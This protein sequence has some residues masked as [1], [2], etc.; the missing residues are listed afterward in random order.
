MAM[1]S[2][3]SGD[4]VRLPDLQITLGPFGFSQFLTTL[5]ELNSNCQQFLVAEGWWRRNSRMAYRE[6]NPR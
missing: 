2:K 5:P 4:R 6:S 1:A 3:V